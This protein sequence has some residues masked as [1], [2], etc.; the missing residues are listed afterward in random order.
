MA[1][2]RKPGRPRKARDKILSACIMV[3]LTKRE[4]ERVKAEARKAGLTTS[5]LLRKPYREG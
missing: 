5:E 4:F 2:K 1:K 3:Y